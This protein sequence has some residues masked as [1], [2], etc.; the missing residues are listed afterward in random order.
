MSRNTSQQASSTEISSEMIE[1]GARVLS[2]EFELVGY[3]TSKGVATRVYEAMRQASAAS[4]HSR[5]DA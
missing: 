4:A 3:L 5:E 1:A 2:D